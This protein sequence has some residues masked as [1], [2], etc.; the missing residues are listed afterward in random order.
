LFDLDGF[1][2]GAVELGSERTA[3]FEDIGPV[4]GVPDWFTA[5]GYFAMAG[6]V[7]EEIPQAL[8]GADVADAAGLSGGELFEGLGD[9]G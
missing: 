6:G 5:Y 3:A 8:G 7:L 2:T 1:V 4:E 9:D